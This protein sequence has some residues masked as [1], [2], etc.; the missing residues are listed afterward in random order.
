[1][2]SPYYRF[3]YQRP[4]FGFNWSGDAGGVPWPVRSGVRVELGNDAV[5]ES[6]VP[7]DLHHPPFSHG[8]YMTP[9]AVGGC[10][11]LPTSDWPAVRPSG[12]EPLDPGRAPRAALGFIAGLSDMEKSALAIGGAALVAYFVFG[13]KKR[14]R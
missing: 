8:R 12:P 6:F 14:K 4:R 5:L 13:K 7:Y 9:P 11:Q 1:M 10:I 2:S 3:G